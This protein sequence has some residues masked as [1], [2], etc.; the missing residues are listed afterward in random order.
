MEV[1]FDNS[2]T[3]KVS[4]SVQELVVKVMTEDFGNPSSMH[5]VGV[6]AEKY[7]KTAQENIA[8][9]LKVDP[10]E[11]YFTSGGTESNNMAIIGSARA[12]QR[13]GKRILTTAVEHSSVG[14]TMKYL[15]EEGFEVI[16]LPV[17]S[18]GVVKMEALQEAMTEETI[19]VSIIHVNNEVGA[20]QPIEEIGTYIKKVN[21]K[22]VFHVDA[23]QSYGKMEIRPKNCKIDLLSV[24]GHKIHGP[25]GSGFIYIK[26]NTKINPIIFG[27]GQQMGLRSGTE[28]VPGIAG[29]GQA[30][31]DCY[32]HLEENVQHIT[33]VKDYMIDALNTLEGVTVNSRKGEAGAPH[34]VSASFSG[35]RSEVLLHALEDKGVYISAGSAC[36][37]NKPAISSTLKAM[38]VE[39]ELLDSTVRFSFCEWNT[40]EEVDYAVEQLQ[41]LLPMLRKYVRR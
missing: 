24:S 20:I 18:F 1:Y 35:V 33:E 36:S 17:D 2:A 40:K 29:I 16:Y 7:I 21:P 34:I 41:Q 4:P 32:D 14:A 10:K 8:K 30:A 15:E 38:G 3:T 37:S 13:S 6:E 31:K 22:V 25:K 11:I 19:L 5:L 9:T 28:N 39:K 12:N 23:I 26:K 27:G